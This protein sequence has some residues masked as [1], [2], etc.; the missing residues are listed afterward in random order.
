M[1]YVCDITTSHVT[2]INESYRTYTHL[3]YFSVMSYTHVTYFSELWPHFTHTYVCITH[4][5]HVYTSHI[6][7]R[8]TWLFVI[9]HTYVTYFNASCHTYEGVMSHMSMSHVTHINDTHFSELWR[10]FYTQICDIW[11]WYN[12]TTGKMWT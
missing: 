8:H 12:I 3:T 11:V 6:F 9:S 7:Q 4:I 2:H 5:S 10:H 1:T